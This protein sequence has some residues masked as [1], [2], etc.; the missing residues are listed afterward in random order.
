MT[1]NEFSEDAI[2]FRVAIEYNCAVQL[3]SRMMRDTSEAAFSTHRSDY[4][5]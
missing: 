1:N 4:V 2:A 3:N 5:Y